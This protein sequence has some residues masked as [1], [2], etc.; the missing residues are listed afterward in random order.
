MP[1]ISVERSD[2]S[3]SK[4]QLTVTLDEFLDIAKA[5]SSE[6]R[7][8]ILKQ[9][10]NRTMNVAEIADMFNIPASTAAV[11]IKKL[12]DAGLIRTE[13]IP[14][15]RGTQK[16]CATVFSR[17]VVETNATVREQDNHVVIP[18]PIG[19]FFDFDVSPTCGLV[20]DT[21]I[22]GE[23]DDPRSFYEPD[24]VSAQLIWFRRGYL[25]YRFP[26]RV[27]HG[28]HI[29]NLEL[30]MELCSEAPLYNP[31]W[32]SD[33]TVW[34]NGVEIGTWTSPGD[35]GGEPGL[36]TPKWWGI[37]NTQYGL[38]KTWRVSDNGSFV[39]GRQISNVVLD[40]LR[41]DGTP[42][43][44]VRI[45]VKPHAH[46]DGGINLFGRRF[47]NYETDLSMRLDYVHRGRQDSSL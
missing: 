24:R 30:T 6:L 10:I 13:M 12:E 33:I 28:S 3:T 37:Q 34:I 7:I 19:H 27:P 42:F 41:V 32:P 14:G 21:A 11:N 43:L 45:G 23:L 18:M 4:R 39:D 36:L 25:E 8:E 44:T 47:G 15:T 35:F 29:T 17:I 38:L 2:I 9:L 31:D 5:L 20:S 16:A 40:D 22:I 26:N 46:N 1:E